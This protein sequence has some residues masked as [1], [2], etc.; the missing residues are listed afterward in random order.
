VGPTFGRA[1]CCRSSC[2][3]PKLPLPTPPNC[4]RPGYM[5]PGALFFTSNTRHP[6]TRTVTGA[7]RDP[8]HFLPIHCRPNLPPH[9][10]PTF[11][12]SRPR[13]AAPSISMQLPRSPRPP[14][15]PHRRPVLTA[16]PHIHPHSRARRLVPATFPI[17]LISALYLIDTKVCSVYI[18]IVIWM[19]FREYNLEWI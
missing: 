9:P 17:L 14:P 8:Q 7:Y 5:H 19:W 10:P 3:R 6:H 12:Y 2:P 13:L 15:R 18:I 11:H 16:A 4:M 1:P